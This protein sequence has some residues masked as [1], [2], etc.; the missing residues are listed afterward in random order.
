MNP[1]GVVPVL[2][3]D[4]VTVVESNDIIQ[5]LDDN[6]D[7]LR[8]SPESPE[9]RDFLKQAA[10]RSSGIQSALKLVSHEFLFKPARRLNARQLR[11]YEA[12]CADPGLLEF[13]RTFSSKE[14][15]CD[16]LIR[17]S[18]KALI[19]AFE[20]LEMRLQ[21]NQWLSGQNYGLADISWIVN[22]H[23]LAHMNYP[24]ERYPKLRGWLDR[25]RHRASFQKAIAGYE[26]KATLAAFKVYS[27]WRSIRKTDIRRVELGS[28]T[29]SGNGS[30]H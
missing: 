4:G 16:E 2:V 1:N 6:F 21:S 27:A 5:Y 19:E 17:N 9:D 25:I 7:G 20:Y 29:H 12:N 8:L 23:R 10:E 15:F 30:S 11:D 26:S 28:G 14:G 3:H 18:V 22:V 13:M 24:F